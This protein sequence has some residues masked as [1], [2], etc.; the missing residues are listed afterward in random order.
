MTKLIYRARPLSS[1][2][3]DDKPPP[4]FPLYRPLPMAQPPYE[5]QPH[6]SAYIDPN[7]LPSDRKIREATK[8]Q[9]TEKAIQD[10]P[11]LEEDDLRSFYAAV[12]E[13]G[14]PLESDAPQIEDG[15][16]MSIEEQTR[17]IE[18]LAVRLIGT[19]AGPSKLPTVHSGL[20]EKVVSDI[21]QKLRTIQVP[22][23]EEG[24]RVPLG[25]VS[26]TEWSVLLE[27]TAARD[28]REAESLMDL[29][30]VS[31]CGSFAMSC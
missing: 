4:T 19:E 22:A 6:R 21:V 30:S 25:L 16:R 26:R 27:E 3:Y 17:V 14:R 31:P 28:G 9:L 20:R 29:M 11:E 1:S 24:R 12:M 13:S 2:T 5:S 10:L 15:Q 18:G 7:S 8:I 23:T